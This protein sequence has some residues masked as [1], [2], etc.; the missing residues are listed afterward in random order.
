MCGTFG[1]F[2]YNANESTL[3]MQLARMRCC[4]EFLDSAKWNTNSRHVRKYVFVN[5]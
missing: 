4:V 5:K 1:K 3:I 2:M